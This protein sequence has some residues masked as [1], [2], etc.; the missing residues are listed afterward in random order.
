MKEF[1][2]ENGPLSVALNANPLQT[3]VSGILDISSN[4]CKA[5]GINH[6]VSLVGYG[7]ASVDYWIIKNSWGNNWGESGFFRIRRGN[8]T[9]GVNCYVLTALV[10]F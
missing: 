5:S 2:Y 7:S 6:A 3:Y 8:G 10:S 1:L 9:C 4:K